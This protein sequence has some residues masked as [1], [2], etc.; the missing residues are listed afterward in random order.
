VISPARA[1]HAPEEAAALAKAVA[2]HR[3][4]ESAIEHIEQVRADTEEKLMRLPS[5]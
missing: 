4:G 1:A 3:D 2:V 5:R